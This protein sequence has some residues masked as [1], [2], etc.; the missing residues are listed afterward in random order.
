MEGDKMA[1]EQRN[2]SDAQRNTN[3]ATQHIRE[4]LGWQKALKKIKASL[5]K[6]RISFKNACWMS[7]ERLQIGVPEDNYEKTHYD[8]GRLI[9]W[10]FPLALDER[11]D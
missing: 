2:S 5:T 11:I 1:G 4:I 3:W 6:T 7:V 8:T 10:L 9:G